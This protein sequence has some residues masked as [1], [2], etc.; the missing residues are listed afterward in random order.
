MHPFWS[1]VGALWGLPD[2]ERILTTRGPVLLCPY[3]PNYPEKVFSEVHIQQ[4]TFRGRR[5]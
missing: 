3:P 5:I 4:P 2:R 1:G